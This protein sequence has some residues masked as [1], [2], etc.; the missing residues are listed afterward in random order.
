MEV[1]TI[2]QKKCIL[3][4]SH[5]LPASLLEDGEVWLYLPWHFFFSNIS[6]LIWQFQVVLK[7]WYS[8]QLSVSSSLTHAYASKISLANFK[9]PNMLSEDSHLHIYIA[10]ALS[11]LRDEKHCSIH[12]V[13]TPA[14]KPALQ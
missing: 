1:S 4:S 9:E 10:N 14:R 8:I 6:G 5:L 2:K 11:T 7:Y 3:F 12:T 13:W